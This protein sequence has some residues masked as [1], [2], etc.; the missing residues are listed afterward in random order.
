MRRLLQ[1]TTHELKTPVAAVRSLLQSLEIHSIPEEQRAQLIARGILECDRLEHLAE[2]ILTYQRVVSSNPELEPHSS[3]ELLT[4]VLEHRRRTLHDERVHWSPGAE[5][6][7]RAE[8]DS[9]R[10]I[11]ENLLDNARK[12]AG[13]EVWLSE[14]VHANRWELLVR[15]RGSG[16]DPQN[17]QALFDPFARAARS[18]TSATHGAGLGLF[19]S[20][21]LAREMGGELSAVSAGAGSGSTFTLAL[22]LAEDGQRHG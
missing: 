2:A 20:R 5:R 10:V 4:Q 15:D 16:F 8:P 9:F 11:L 3:R 18:E 6:V 14:Q 12:Y 22:E 7:V 19:I 21:R 17:A 13:G 1:F